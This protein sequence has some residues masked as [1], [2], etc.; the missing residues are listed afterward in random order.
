MSQGIVVSS[1]KKRSSHSWNKGS[2]LGERMTNLWGPSLPLDLIIFQSEL[3]PGSA[4]ASEFCQSL[5]LECPCPLPGHTGQTPGPSK[6]SSVT[7]P[8]RTPSLG[9][10]S[11][12]INHPP[13]AVYIH[14]SVAEPCFIICYHVLSP[15]SAFASLNGLK[16]S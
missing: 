2:F 9:V 14:T 1:Q 7:G 5:C 4:A 10:S 11:E 3:C 16:R 12:R 6:P 8:C 15:M 13:L